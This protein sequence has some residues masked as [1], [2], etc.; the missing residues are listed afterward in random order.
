M[1]PEERAVAIVERWLEVFDRRWPSKAELDE[2]LTP[3][4]RFVEHPNLVS[5][6]G[7]ER[8]REAM[9]AGIEAGRELLAWQADEPLGHVV[10]GDTVA[11]RLRWSGELAIDA[12]PW[13]KGTRLTAWCVAH[14]ELRD[15]RIASIE[16]HDCYEPPA[17]P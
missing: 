3:D 10:S 15:G 16:H 4:A 14:Y 13:A 17:V 9:E 1:T 6:R 5:P 7:G 12:G 11:T 8:D 2:L